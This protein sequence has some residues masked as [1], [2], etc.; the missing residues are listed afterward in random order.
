MPTY[1]VPE[2]SSPGN[3]VDFSTDFEDMLINYVY[4]EWGIADPPKP[5]NMVGDTKIQFRPGFPAYN[6]PYEVLCLQH[7]TTLIDKV[8]AQQYHYQTVCE[9]RLVENHI[10]RDQVDPQLGNMEREIQRIVNQHKYNE[11]PGIHRILYLSSRRL[12]DPRDTYAKSRWESVIRVGM[13]YIKVNIE[14]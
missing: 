6:T 14:V 10:K 12:Y 9:I 4:Q 11:I 5:A 3:A 8:S 2:L 13:N 7:E 1:G